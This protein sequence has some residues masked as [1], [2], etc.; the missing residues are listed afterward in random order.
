MKRNLIIALAFVLTLVLCLSA[1][2]PEKKVSAITVVEGTL[3]AEYEVGDTVDFSGLKA[4]IS[5]NDGS[6]E[7]VTADKLGLS[8]IDTSTAGTKKLTITYKDFSIDVDITVSEKPE[9]TL[10]KIEVV[11]GSVATE[12]FIGDVLDTSGIQATATYS[13]GTTKALTATDL[14]VSEIDTSTVG[15]KTLTVTYEGVSTTVTIKVAGITSMQIVSG[16]LANEVYVGKTLDTSS[17]E[18]LVTYSSGKSEVVKAASLTL[19]ELDTSVMGDKVLAITY[20]GFTLE[21][22]VK[23]VG[24]TEIEINKGTVAT[25]VKVGEALDTSTLTAMARYNNDTSKSLANSEL[26]IGTVDTSTAGVKQLTVSYNGVEVTLDVTVV[27]VKTLSVVSGSLKNELLVGEAL[28]TSLLQVHVVYTD[29][30]E[31]SIGKDKLT[32]G[33]IDT[34]TVGNKTL[35]ITYLD[36]TESFTVTVCGIESLRVEGITKV[37]NAGETP[38]LS[39]MKVYAVYSNSAKTEVL[40]DAQYIT[41]NVNELD[42]NTEGDKQLA[43]SYDGTLGEYSTTVII[44]TEPPVLTSIEIRTYDAIVRLGDVYNK[45]NVTATAFYGN[46][47]NDVITNDKLTVSDI[48]TDVAGNV[49]LTVTYTEDGVTKEATATVKVLPITKLAVSGLA[50]KVDF[51]GTYDTSAVSVTVTYS[52]GTDTLTKV[53]GIADGVTV[54]A[55]NTQAAGDQTLTVSYLGASTELT[56]HV[57][58]VASIEILDGTVSGFVRYGYAIDTAGLEVKVTY[59]DNT[60]VIKKISELTVNYGSTLIKG[61][62]KNPAKVTLTVTYTENTVAASATKQIEVLQVFSVNAING[63][64]NTSVLLGSAYSIEGVK[65][66]VIYT[67]IAGTEYIYLVGQDD[68]NLSIDTSKIDTS[69]PGDKALLFGYMKTSGGYEFTAAMTITVKG[70]SK[71]TVVEGTIQTQ[72]NVD[73]PFN[74]ADIKVKIEFTDGTY[75]YVDTT[76]GKLKLGSIDTSTAGDKTFRI[77]YLG[78]VLDVIIKVYDVNVSENMIFGIE[79]PDNIVARNSYKL[80]FKDQTAPYVVGNMNPY[81]FYLNVLVLNDKDELVDVDGS[82]VAT[83]A[84]VYLID[85]GETLLEGEA[86]TAMVIVDSEKNTYQF[87]EAAKGKTFRIEARPKDNYVSDAWLSHTV[88][89][90]EAYNIYDAKELNLLTN[91]SEDMNGGSMEG[92]L[93]SLTAVNNFLAANNIVRPAK[94]PGIVLHSNIDVE[95][96]DIPSEFLYEYTNRNGVTKKEF[97]EQF[98]VFHHQLDNSQ[99]EFTLHGNYYTIYTYHLPCVVEN[100]Y[101]NNDDQFSSSSIFRFSLSWALRD[102]R[103]EAETVNVLDYHTYIQNTAF[104]DNDPNSNDQSA[105]ERHMR[106][107]S[108]MKLSFC[109]ANVTNTNID[110]YY[111][112]CVLEDDNLLVNL[113]KVKFY[114]AWQNHLFVWNSNYLS[115]AVGALNEEPFANY[116]NMKVNITD[117]LLAKCGGPVILSQNKYV[118][119]P[120]GKLT[121]ADIVVDEKSE[122][123]SYV[124]GQEAWFVA[125]NQTAMA[126]QILAMSQL[127]EKSAWEQHSLG[128][129]YTTTDKIEGVPTIN[130]I[131]VNMGV[132]LNIGTGE[133]Y[134]GTFTKKTSGGDVVGL[135]MT[136]NK[137]VDDLTAAFQFLV[138]N[139]MVDAMPPVFQSSDGGTCFS[140]GATGCYSMNTQTFEQGYADASCFSGDYITLYYLGMGIMLEYF[141]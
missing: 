15:D 31:E 81:R 9:V 64:V 75:T 106:G 59:T 48:K 122:L 17:I 121:G 4:I 120:A 25:S 29:N 37:I 111:L 97:Y 84:R 126:G 102:T 71:L 85:G 79:L 52:D 5:Y 38:E 60:S 27:G 89:V 65:L 20:R 26:T 73:Q 33:S 140:D 35:D 107:L 92:Y 7:T 30:T 50:S 44:S 49:T 112:S 96:D 78:T 69:K 58:A 34:S 40:L 55:L 45:A 8:A 93:D 116:F 132:G 24:V 3:N 103:A 135:D 47:T 12:L 101:A 76:D 19:G 2:T 90:V 133:D 22:A 108:C 117:S 94:L 77:E 134:R 10:E 46:G 138:D 131:Y 98:S 41:T 82:K 70:V 23:V 127:V 114:N 141:N 123:Y 95:V 129:S 88:T 36:K 11:P 119:Y 13:D 104:R 21:F 28:D 39:G 83:V 74:V 87:T 66:T 125:V 63:T 136:A 43:V 14:T 118:N 18:A 67:D 137:D 139:K 72:L 115:D 57:K 86:L 42:F 51:G 91:V 124:T 130:M 62:K 1:C 56:V 100:G 80:N 113:D 32:L 68:I 6:A 105:S 61:D 16:T 128:A 53:V 109:E 54:S 110:A 99:K